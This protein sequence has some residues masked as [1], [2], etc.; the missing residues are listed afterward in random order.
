[1][2]ETLLRD[3]LQTQERGIRNR[4][5]ARLV[6][7]ALVVLATAGAGWQLVRV[8]MPP[9]WAFLVRWWPAATAGVALTTAGVLWSHTR[10]RPSAGRTKVSGG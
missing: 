1:M 6:A 5:R 4:Q 7:L 9:S 10:R 2:G 8:G 3:A